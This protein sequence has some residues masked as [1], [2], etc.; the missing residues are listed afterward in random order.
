M[1]S[2]GG[3]ALSAA[4]AVYELCACWRGC[5]C[6]RQPALLWFLSCERSST[7][8]QCAPLVRSCL[9]QL[10]IVA[11]TP[12]FVVGKRRAIAL[13]VPLFLAVLQIIWLMS[14]ADSAAIAAQ[15]PA[16]ALW[17]SVRRDM[18]SKYMDRTVD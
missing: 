11:V 10:A 8:V 9:S 13:E 18:S 12:S 2:E 6:A 16:I 3:V 14:H 5:R 1:L 7:P 15:R 4:V 17:F